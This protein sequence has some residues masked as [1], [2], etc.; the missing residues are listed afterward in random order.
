MYCET[1]PQCGSKKVY[2]IWQ[3]G[4]TRFCGCKTCNAQW[5][6]VTENV[7]RRI[8]DEQKRLYPGLH[9]SHRSDT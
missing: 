9:T 6:E 4:N 3:D 5:P 1:C 8:D 2:I 7:L